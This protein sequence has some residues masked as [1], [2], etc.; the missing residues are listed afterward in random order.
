MLLPKLIFDIFKSPLTRPIALVS[1][2]SF[3]TSVAIYFQIRL[4]IG[5]YEQETVNEYLFFRRWTAIVDAFVLLGSFNVIIEKVKKNSSGNLFAS[6]SLSVILAAFCIVFITI[7]YGLS[8]PEDDKS[9]IIQMNN[10]PILLIAFGYSIYILNY[11]LLKIHGRF[12]FPDFLQ[13]MFLGVSPI[14]LLY[15]GTYFDFS[16][17]FL[18]L[19]SY[20]PVIIL[21]I[22]LSFL[23][24]KTFFKPPDIFEVKKFIVFGFPRFLHFNFQNVVFFFLI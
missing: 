10:I 1:I 4:V 17:G 21:G 15:T 22:G 5:F 9:V 3:G 13:F 7:L 23:N 24:L 20:L 18:A 2:L 16:G 14:L 19:C 12:V 8:F 6:Y 11:L